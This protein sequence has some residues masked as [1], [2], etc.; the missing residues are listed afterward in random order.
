MS[1]KTINVRFNSIDFSHYFG[2]KVGE[3]SNYKVGKYY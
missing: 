1:P 3:L 2:E